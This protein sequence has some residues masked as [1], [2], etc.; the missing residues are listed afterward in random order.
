MPA[1]TR[2]SR[3][4]KENDIGAAH[5]APD[6]PDSLYMT[7]H[8]DLLAGLALAAAAL[9]APAPAGAQT[10][11]DPTF[12]QEYTRQKSIYHDQEQ[13]Y[14]EGYVT[15]RTLDDY[16][17]AL[18]AGFRPALQ[19]LGPED[20]W[21]DIG[22]G[23]GQAI[24]DY[25]YAAGP[26]AA[27]PSE[28]RALAMKAGAVA[29]SIEDR[30]T[31]RWKQ[32]AERLG[33]AR[34]QY[35]YSKTLREYSVEELGRF[36]L[37]T[38]VIGGFSYTANLALFME[39]TLRFLTVDGT[40]YTVLQDVRREDG[41]NKPYYEGS[42]FLTRITDAGGADVGVCAWLKRIGCVQVSCAPR[43]DWKP[44]LEVYSVR[45]VCED[46]TVPPLRTVRFTAGTPPERVFQLADEP[47][48]APA[49]QEAAR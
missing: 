32:A 17:D 46:V 39:T 9:L 30:R 27:P 37:I 33:P 36:R 31:A 24:L 21:L 22:A 10:P 35:V 7:R 3:T 13:E 6:V 16:A 34:L 18:P 25:Y 29:M 8:A 48:A 43:D 11:A 44:P 23:R 5:D 14:V 41:A 12:E 40:F 20:R 42:P 47:A 38:D 45:K 15:D 2:D 4:R 1:G 49:R 19:A 28:A 26:D